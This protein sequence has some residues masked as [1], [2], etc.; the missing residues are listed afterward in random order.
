MRENH[1][2]VELAEQRYKYLTEIFE[3][4]KLMSELKAKLEEPISDVGTDLAPLLK[5]YSDRYYLIDMFFR[6]AVHYI[7]K[8][9]DK[10]L[11]RILELLV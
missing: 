8:A 6:R 9:T 4:K 5:H 10:P 3:E 11:Q 2:G 7:G 1:R